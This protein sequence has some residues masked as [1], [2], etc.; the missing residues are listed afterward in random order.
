M[1][2]LGM[3]NLKTALAVFL[4]LL[5]SRYFSLEY[6][7]YASIAAIFAMENT[8]TNSLLAGKNRIVGTIIG[9]GVGLVFALMRPGDPVLSGVGIVVVIYL[10]NLFKVSKSVRIAGVVF[11]AIMVSLNHKN[12]LEY[13][14]NRILDTV[15]GIAIAVAVNY[16][17]FPPNNSKQIKK[18]FASL[19][20]R[21]LELSTRSA[22]GDI[23]DLRGIEKEITDLQALVDTYLNE[24]R[25]KKEAQ[26]VMEGIN[27]ELEVFQ[28]MLVH[29]KLI[30]KLGPGANGPGNDLRAVYNF[31]R[32][33]LID[34]L[35][36][37][38][39]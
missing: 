23:I 16:V 5:L 18:D 27:C 32:D 9:A 8:L 13:S 25:P 39:T 24:Y 6:P 4:C 7:F 34:S 37:V 3:R 38:Q 2:K 33:K 28:E 10:C 30:Q 21:I 29:L 20:K 15:V 19:K 11:L 22:S 26:K 35:K 14:L 17:V 12:P 36:L 31:H 1:V